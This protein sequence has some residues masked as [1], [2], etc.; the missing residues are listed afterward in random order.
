MIIDLDDG[1]ISANKFALSAGT[2]ESGII[3]ISNELFSIKKGSNEIKL[4]ITE[5]KFI[6]ASENFNLAEDG[7]VT[8]TGTVTATGGEIGGCEIKDGVL[9]VPAANISGRLTVNQLDASVIT[10]ENFS[11]QKINADQITAGTIKA[12]YIDVPGLV[13][14]GNIVTV[15][16]EFSGTLSAASG[17]FGSLTANGNLY[18]NG[19]RIY[20][21]G[22]DVNRYF[23]YSSSY[24]SGGAAVFVNVNVYTPTVY[25][26]TVATNNICG[27][28]YPGAGFTGSGNTFLKILGDL[29]LDAGKVKQDSEGYLYI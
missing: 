7:S 9:T 3:T 28:R 19:K 29:Y 1:K 12:D 5:N 17:T 18:M 6:I 16:G 26:Y 21:Q 4:D 2:E 8:L 15:K 13:K 27:L 22:K 24:G 11:A 20:F 25:A 10:T 14:D 23:E